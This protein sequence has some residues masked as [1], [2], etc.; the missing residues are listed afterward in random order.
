MD[1]KI[2]K[3]KKSEFREIAKI[4]TEIFSKPPYNDRW[5]E[6]LALKK[7]KIFSK[8]C[9]IYTLNLGKEMVGFLILNPYLFVPGVVV[10]GEELAIKPEYQGKG[11]GK[12]TIKW[13][14][15]E[16]KKKG[17][18]SLQ[19]LSLKTSKAYKMYKKWGYK[20]DKQQAYF[21]KELK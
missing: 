1:L 17:F 19:F 9:D 6:P 10:Y 18:K 3:A 20:E 4:Y 16:Y 14:E 8:Y 12:Y 15:K 11:F 2:K 21:A 7:V 13:V 5:T